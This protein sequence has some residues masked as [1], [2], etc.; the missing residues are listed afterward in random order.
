LQPDK[1]EKFKEDNSIIEFI[2]KK[3]GNKYHT[4]KWENHSYNRKEYMKNEI[5]LNKVA[6]DKLKNPIYRFIEIWRKI[7]IKYIMIL[8]KIMDI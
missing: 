5:E 2:P 8:L 4:I 7:K 3:V 6:K 1:N